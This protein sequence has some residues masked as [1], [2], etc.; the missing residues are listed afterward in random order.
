MV[1]VV[2]DVIRVANMIVVGVLYF[3]VSL[4]VGMK[5]VVVLVGLWW[6]W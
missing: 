4:K 5:V 1:G 3:S 2:G 6:G